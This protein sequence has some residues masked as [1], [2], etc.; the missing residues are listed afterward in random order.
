LPDWLDYNGFTWLPKPTK[1]VIDANGNRKLNGNMDIEL[2]SMR[3]SLPTA[4]ITS[5]FSPATA[6]LEAVQRRGV[7][8]IVVS[9][10]SSQPP[11]IADE[12]RR[13]ADEFADLTDL[14]SGI[15]RSPIVRA[16]PR[17][18]SLRT[19]LR[20][21]AAAVKR[22]PRAWGCQGLTDFQSGRLRG[23]LRLR[24]EVRCPVCPFYD[25]PDYRL[26]RSMIVKLVGWAISSKIPR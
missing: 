25:N 13:Q 19:A 26:A 2:Q 7:R 12:L 3:C 5:C 8:V 15:G 4:S 24:R 11:M 22:R 10:I 6:I 17:E 1:E 9:T 21:P 16:I 20:P 14:Q 23:N 18:A